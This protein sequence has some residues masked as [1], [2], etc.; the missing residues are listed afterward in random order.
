MSGRR[1]YSFR[2]GDR[3]EYF[4]NFLLS[5]IGLTNPIPRQEDIGFD[6]YCL[7]SEQEKSQLITFGTPFLIQIKSD[8]VKEICYGWNKKEKKR[9]KEGIDMLFKQDLPIFIGSV[10]KNE[11]SIKIYATSTLNFIER[12]NPNALMV[13]LK[14]RNSQ[15]T[16]PIERPSPYKMDV[17]NLFDSDGNN[18]M[19]DL[20]NPLIEFSNDDLREKSKERI[21]KMKNI[22]REVIEV[23]RNNMIY[24]KLNLPH[25]QWVRSVK[26]NE[27]VSFAWL[28]YE[29]KGKSSQIL[30][31]SIPNLV[32]AY[33]SLNEDNN[34][35]KIRK[36]I[37]LLLEEIG[38][39]KLQPEIANRI[40]NEN[41]CNNA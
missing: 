8:S 19:V 37:Y 18:Y 27:E 36:S 41:S 32:S 23:E 24:R 34:Q 21:S 20:G 16:K 31:S 13:T 17:E 15:S 6:F 2:E 35:N 30:E 29:S 33:L 1:L 11:L 4:A 3:A 25:F 22:L 38:F 7:L 10:N 5:G 39:D 14:P 9:N 28:Y 40:K 12:E 26:T